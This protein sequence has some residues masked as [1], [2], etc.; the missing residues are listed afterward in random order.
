[1]NW[2]YAL[3]GQQQGP[4]SELDLSQLVAS[5]TINGATLIWS[6]G[7]ADWQPLAQALPGALSVVPVNAPQIGGF[8]VPAAQKDLYVQQMR[9]GVSPTMPG[10]M[11]FA[12]FWLR[13]VAKLIDSLILMVPNFAVQFAIGLGPGSMANPPAQEVD[14]AQLA[15]TLGALAFSVGLSVAYQTILVSKYG[16]TWGKMALGL[17]IVNEDGSKV[18]TGRAFGRVFAEIL[19]GM[20]CYIGYIIVAFDSEKRSLHDHICATRVIKSR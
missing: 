14:P 6:D 17:K 10:T 2:Y 11:E 4:V 12:G 18:R 15:L 8:A 9:E 1:M 20:T 3:N 13:L 19:S 16:A 5:G 7:L